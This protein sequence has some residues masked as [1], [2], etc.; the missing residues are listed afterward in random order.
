MNFDVSENGTQA[1]SNVV[2][3]NAAKTSREDA[4]LG[5]RYTDYRTDAAGSWLISFPE[6]L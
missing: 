6:H 1:A 3:M 2:Y 5:D 4:G